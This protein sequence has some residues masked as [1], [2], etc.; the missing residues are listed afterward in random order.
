MITYEW[1]HDD[2]AYI[3][4]KLGAMKSDARKV[5]KNAVN[6]T[7]VSARVKLR[8]EAQKR[9]TVKAAGVNSRI[10]IFRATISAPTATLKV[11]GRT[12]TMPRFRFMPEIESGIKAKILKGT[13][14]KVVKGS[15][16]IK[17]FVSKVASG[18]KK[19]GKVT[20]TTQILQRVG[21][22]RYPLK[23]LR[24]PSVPK[25][26]EM[27]YDGKRITSTPLR[28]EIERLYKHYVD[29]EIERTLNSK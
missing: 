5:L 1:N 12:L 2:L 14:F 10:D 24:S 7:A 26:I 11:K 9:Y 8:Q 25:M 15:K 3:E 21:R 17:A 19:S 18:S 13:A 23:V 22:E 27:V 4:R 29:Q 6:K 20:M 28:R 16:G